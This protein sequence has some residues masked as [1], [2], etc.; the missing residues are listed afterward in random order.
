M[1]PSSSISSG[2]QSHPSRKQRSL[3]L[4]FIVAIGVV[5][6]LLLLALMIFAG[7]KLGQQ[8]DSERRY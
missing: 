2:Q 4:P 6:N 8:A 7:L 1:I 3:S 5:Q